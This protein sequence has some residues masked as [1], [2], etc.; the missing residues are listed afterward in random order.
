MTAVNPNGFKKNGSCVLS[1]LIC[2]RYGKTQ[3]P[4]YFLV[5]PAQSDNLPRPAFVPD[6]NSISPE[7]K[8]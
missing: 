7:R 3:L 4:S 2:E 8:T 5:Q 6:T 1:R